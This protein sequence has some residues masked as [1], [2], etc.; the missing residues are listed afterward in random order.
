MW[1]LNKINNLN[2]KKMIKNQFRFVYVINGWHQFLLLLLLSFLVTEIHSNVEEKSKNISTVHTNTHTS[3][4]YLFHFKIY[5]KKKFWRISFLFFAQQPI[6]DCYFEAIV[7][8]KKKNLYQQK[9]IQFFSFFSTNT[10]IFIGF[11]FIFQW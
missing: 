8:M 3:S 2:R 11:I 1:I 5:L 6:F 7:I 4:T 9:K 10:A